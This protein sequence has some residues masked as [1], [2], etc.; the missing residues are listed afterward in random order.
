MSDLY[1]GGTTHSA[2]YNNVT[3]TGKKC[4]PSYGEHRWRRLVFI[5]LQSVRTENSAE[6]EQR[7]YPA[8]RCLTRPSMRPFL[9]MLKFMPNVMTPT[10]AFNKASPPWQQGRYSIPADSVRTS[11]TT[12]SNINWQWA[13]TRLWEFP[14][15]RVRVCFSNVHRFHWRDMQQLD[16]H[17]CRFKHR[18]CSVWARAGKEPIRLHRHHVQQHLPHRCHESL[19]ICSVPPDLIGTAPIK[20]LSA[21]L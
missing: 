21:C 4:N 20:G 8:R 6:P 16:H 13:H 10:V 5:A 2:T 9:K 3:C 7:C 14:T 1:Q 19:T 17:Q 18:R 11:C 12:M 15:S